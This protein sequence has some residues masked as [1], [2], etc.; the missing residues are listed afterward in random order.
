MAKLVGPEGLF[1]G[2]VVLSPVPVIDAHVVHDYSLGFLIGSLSQGIPQ[3]GHYWTPRAVEG[4]SRWLGYYPMI[5]V[6]NQ[7]RAELVWSALELGYTVDELLRKAT[8]G[9][10]DRRVKRILDITRGS[11]LSLM[12]SLRSL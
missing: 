1:Y 2:L 8:V 9:L 12:D 3:D 10:Y 4:E 7:R 5:A 11:I 6:P